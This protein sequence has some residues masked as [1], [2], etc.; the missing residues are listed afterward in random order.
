M[1]F[2]H[3]VIEVKKREVSL[4]KK[5]V[6]FWEMQGR[7]LNM[8]TKPHNFETAISI[9][10]GK[11]HIIAEV[12]KASP[13]AG[14]IVEH[15]QPGKIARDYQ[16]NEVSAL[17]VLT[18]EKFFHGNI[19]HLTVVKEMTT[20]P[21]LRKDFIIDEYQIYEARY[22]GADAV[23]L[24][25]GILFRKE[26]QKFLTCARE[27]GL[28]CLVEVHTESELRKVLD[29]DAEIIGIN[30]RNLSTLRVDIHTTERLRPLIPPGKVVVSESG[31]RS[32]EDIKLLKNMDINAI[33]IGHY[34]LEKKDSVGKA[35]QE[36]LEE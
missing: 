1:N 31:I 9:P 23:L 18:D 20:L 32:K 36:L 2:L 8:H 11:L 35:L 22:Y 27:I 7:L 5:G 19:Q 24:I 33:L 34:L 14:V 6:S 26:L 12:K 28:H 25:A 10:K 29:T 16:N 15:Y 21:I 17:S 13:S 30:N 4:A 3:K